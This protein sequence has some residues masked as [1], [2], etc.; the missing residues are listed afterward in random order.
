VDVVLTLV[1]ARSEKGSLRDNVPQ[2]GLGGSPTYLM[3]EAPINKNQRGA[4][5]DN[6]DSEKLFEKIKNRRHSGKS[7]C[8]SGY[9]LY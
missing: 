5:G 1:P 9:F 3:R 4:A 8:V 7:L 6:S 2:A